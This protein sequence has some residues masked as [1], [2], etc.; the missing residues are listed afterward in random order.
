MELNRMSNTVKEKWEAIGHNLGLSSET[1][2]ALKQKHPSSRLFFAVINTWLH[3]KGL[4]KDLPTYLPVTLR[5]LVRA[6]QSAEVGESHL[7]DKIVE[8][9]DKGGRY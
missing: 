3:R 8:S 9:K 5:V 4:R 7:A 2:M 6:L 1:L